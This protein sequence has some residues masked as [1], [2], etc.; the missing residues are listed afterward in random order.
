MFKMRKIAFFF[1][2]QAVQTF[3]ENNQLHFN[4][5]GNSLF[6]RCTTV[7]KIFSNGSRIVR[8]FNKM[9]HQLKCAHFMLVSHKINILINLKVKSFIFSALIYDLL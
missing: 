3:D 8:Q 1:L 6:R 9:L 5:H 2:I 7:L 4:L